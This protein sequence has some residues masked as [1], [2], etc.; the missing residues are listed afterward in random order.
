MDAHQLKDS[1]ETIGLIGAALT[2]LWGSIKFAG[3]V[4][5][6]EEIPE[7]VDS[8]KTQI[9]G[10]DKKVDVLTGQFELYREM[11]RGSKH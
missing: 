10:V 7:K 5:K 8:L 6:L 9:E 11:G 4:S 1:F 3:K 2:F